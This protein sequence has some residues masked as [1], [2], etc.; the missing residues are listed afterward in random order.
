MS[1]YI[2]LSV[3][4]SE[5]FHGLRLDQALSELF[6]DY[7]RS[8]MK[9]WIQKGLVTINGEVCTIPRLKVAENQ[10]IIVNAEVEG[11][12]YFIAQ[13]IPINIIYEDDDLLV[14]DKPAGLVVHPGAGCHD[15]TL[16]NA[17]LYHFPQNK[18]LPRAGIVHRLDKDT[19][20]L[21]VV[22][23]TLRAVHKLVKAISRHDVVREYEA[24]AVGHMTAGGSVDEPIGRSST[25]RIMMAVK[26]EGLGKEAITHYRVMEKFRA[27]TRLRLRLETGRTHQIRV[28]MAY[29][30]HPL[31]GDPVYGGKRARF[32][33]NASAEFTHSV[34]T[35]PRQALHAALIEFDHPFTGEHLTFSSPIPQDIMNLI[36][37]LREDTLANP[38]DIVWA[39]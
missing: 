36:E 19:S 30:K 38:D 28:H 17:L 7:S 5:D 34:N 3:T 27:H 22:A 2:Q 25:N 24:I 8:R 14:I 11:D 33:P 39:S 6:S 13:N 20:G 15:G 9:E 32:I 4:I 29:I 16:M 37:L 18:D 23:K 35:F 1:Q 21:M 26:P 12:D 31:V 10:E